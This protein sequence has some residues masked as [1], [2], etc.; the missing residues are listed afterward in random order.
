MT[1]G[2]QFPAPLLS[3]PIATNIAT[4]RN[5]SQSLVASV[6]RHIVKKSV[7]FI[8]TMEDGMGVGEPLQ[9]HC[10]C[11]F[12]R[13]VLVI[14]FGNLAWVSVR[15]NDD[16]KSKSCAVFSVDI[17]WI[18]CS[19]YFFA[20]VCSITTFDFHDCAVQRCHAG[21]GVQRCF[22]ETGLVGLG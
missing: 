3:Q 14:A 6:T 5:P 17:A 13:F 15:S 12:H 1:R 19:V 11:Q 7:R 22:F 18:A 4:H 9:R 16:N 20:I 10:F 2:T 21:F 8:C